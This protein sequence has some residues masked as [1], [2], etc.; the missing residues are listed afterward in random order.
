MVQWEICQS[1]AFL[2]VT[3]RAGGLLDFGTSQRAGF[4][5]LGMNRSQID[6]FSVFFELASVCSELWKPQAQPNSLVPTAG[7]FKTNVR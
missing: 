4:T 1:M 2:R 7:V 3:K 6:E 5:L